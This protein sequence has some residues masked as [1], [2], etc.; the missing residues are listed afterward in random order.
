MSDKTK[1]HD[2]AEDTEGSALRR[3]APAT[4]EAE[5]TEGSGLRFKEPAAVEAVEA[6]DAEGH[7]RHK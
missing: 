5:D 2:E 4:V 3:G 6:D 1:G 7:V